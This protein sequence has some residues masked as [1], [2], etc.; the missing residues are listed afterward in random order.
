MMKFSVLLSYMLIIGCKA[1]F[2]DQIYLLPHRMWNQIIPLLFPKVQPIFISI[3]ALRSPIIPDIL[4][5]LIIFLHVWQIWDFNLGQ[6]RGGHD[7]SSPLE[8]DYGGNDQL[9]TVK[10]YEGLLKETS[11]A[12]RR[13]VDLPGVNCIGHEDIIPFNVSIATLTISVIYSSCICH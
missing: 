3:S 9:Y 4:C 11:S 10:S 6:L 1:N 2:L 5:P 7:E 13:A 8:I 12:K